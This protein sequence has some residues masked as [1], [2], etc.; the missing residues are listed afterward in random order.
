MA[1][2]FHRPAHLDPADA[3]RIEGTQDT[4]SVSALAHASA[5][6]LIGGFPEEATAPITHDIAVHA[7]AKQGV[8]AFAELWADSPATTLPGTL[9][10][11]M[12]LAAWID[13]D[14][15]AIEQR[16]AVTVNTMDDPDLSERAEQALIDSRPAPS[17]NEVRQ[18]LA[19]ALGGET[20]GDLKKLAGICAMAASFMRA[21]AASSDAS[22]ITDDDDP[23]AHHVTRR[24][25]ALDISAD[26]LSESARRAYTGVLD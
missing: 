8:D 23:L 9:W 5:Q 17:M 16:Y 13:R 20:H 10:R 21:L 22:W 18:A 14:P 3:E 6:A 15:Q 4:A 26:E 24:R 25:S 1:R 2:A 19:V 11:L 12:L 7:V